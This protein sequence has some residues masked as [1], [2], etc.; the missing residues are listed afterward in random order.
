MSRAP[1]RCAS[2]A[3]RAYASSCS[4]SA[5][6]AAGGPRISDR[7]VAP[8]ACGRGAASGNDTRLTPD[9]DSVELEV[10]VEDDEVGGRADV[11][12]TE[13]GGAEHAGGD[14]GGGLNRLAQRDAELVQVPHR[15]DHRQR[16]A[17]EHV[18]HAAGD[19]VAYLDLG[20]GEQVRAVAHACAGHGIRDEGDATGPGLRG[21]GDAAGPR[22]PDELRGLGGEVHAVEDDLDDDV[23][24]RE[25]C[26]G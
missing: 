26:A 24:A 1:R 6:S 13:A 4:S 16:A 10:V 20:A 9:A 8:P 22:P 7:K 11:E 15:V 5:R 14:P 25:R 2:A 21:G 23:V 18:V 17:G 3:T 19:A 12:A